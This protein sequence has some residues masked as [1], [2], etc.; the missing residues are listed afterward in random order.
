LSKLPVSIDDIL[1]D[2]ESEEYHLVKVVDLIDLLNQAYEYG[3]KHWLD[4]E[5]LN[6]FRTYA[7]SQLKNYKKRFYF[8]DNFLESNKYLI[9]I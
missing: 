9:E 2:N 4:E 6:E 5:N 3:K 7:L 1:Q 8:L